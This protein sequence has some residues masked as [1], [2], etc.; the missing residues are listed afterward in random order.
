VTTVLV[1][2]ATGSIGRLVVAEAIRHRYRTR[3]LVR[4]R[5][6]ARVLPADAEVVVG[7]VTR[8]DTLPAA[9]TGIDA[10]VFTLGSHGGR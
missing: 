8:P 7:D 1:A 10:V 2:G 6:K 4:D 3:A 9:L 5:D